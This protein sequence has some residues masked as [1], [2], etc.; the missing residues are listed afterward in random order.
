MGMP[1]SETALEEF[2]CRILQD[3]LNEGVIVKIA[4][5]LSVVET[6]LMS[7]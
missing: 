4:D 1:R 7:C 6:Q 3:L 5:D 2:M